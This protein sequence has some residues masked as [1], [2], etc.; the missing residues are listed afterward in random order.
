MTTPRTWGRSPHRP[1]RIT[2]ST[3]S[4]S[5][6]YTPPAA[7]RAC[8]GQSRWR[9]LKKTTHEYSEACIVV[10]FQCAATSFPSTITAK[11]PSIGKRSGIR[12][13]QSERT[14]PDATRRSDQ[15]YTYPRVTHGLESRGS[16]HQ[17][18]NAAYCLRRPLAADNATGNFRERSTRALFGGADRRARRGLPKTTRITTAFRH[19]GRESSSPTRAT[20]LRPGRNRFPDQHQVDRR[21]R[22]TLRTGLEPP[23][24]HAVTM[25]CFPQAFQ[26]SHKDTI[27]SYQGFDQP[28]G[29]SPVRIEAP[30]SVSRQS[31]RRFR[32]ATEIRVADRTE[33]EPQSHSPL[34]I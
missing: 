17:S 8:P 15:S 27:Y 20:G 4:S 2:R 34:R 6:A 28:D 30:L 7:A 26:P 32:K 24:G 5:A 31:P 23:T 29:I 9:C 18:P 21:G 1:L 12:R 33:P 13:V 25:K 14:N 3:N 11:S 22:E 16:V 10:S 19:A